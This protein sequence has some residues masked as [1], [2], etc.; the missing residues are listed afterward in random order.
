MN[1]LLTLSFWFNAR[2]EVL[3]NKGLMIVLIIAAILF[4]IGIAAR[5]NF[6]IAQWQPHRSILR[7]ISPILIT[8]A[9][10]LL[11]F[12]FLDSQ[13]VPILRARAWF[14]FWIL[15]DIAWIIGI[16]FSIKALL[17]R[18][19]DRSQSAEVKKYLPS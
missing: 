14:G 19:K 10:V 13:I 7:K 8:N 9:I 15:I 1:E 2:P 17:Q 11:Y 16:I 4:A 3:T 18:R 6:F 12:W 5:Y